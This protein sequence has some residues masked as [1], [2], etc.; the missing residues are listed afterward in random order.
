MFVLLVDLCGCC[1]SRRCLPSCLLFRHQYTQL[2]RRAKNLRGKV[3]GPTVSPRLVCAPLR[4]HVRTPVGLD[5]ALVIRHYNWK[6]SA[7]L[8]ADVSAGGRL[9]TPSLTHTHTTHT[10]ITYSHL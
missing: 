9:S 4:V 6:A 3:P 7:P 10:H 2:C 8:P 5:R 1:A